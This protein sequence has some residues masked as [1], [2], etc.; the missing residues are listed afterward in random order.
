VGESLTTEKVTLEQGRKWLRGFLKHWEEPADRG[1]GTELPSV[2][3][4]IHR[5]MRPVDE[6]IAAARAVGAGDPLEK[7]RIPVRR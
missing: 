7:D 5:L 6:L 1:P 2:G 4:G 3:V